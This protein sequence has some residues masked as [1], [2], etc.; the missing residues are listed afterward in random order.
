MVV[1]LIIATPD[2][3]SIFIGFFLIVFGMFFRAWSS[4]YINK[5]EELAC[6]GPY[7]LTRNPLYF[8]SF[9]IGM[10]IAVAANNET[11]IVIFGTYFLLFFP[12][13]IIIERRKMKNL[14]PEQ[15]A[16]LARRSNLFIP[17]LKKIENTDFNIAFYFKNKE[18]RVLYLSLFVVA[19]FIVKYLIQI[20]VN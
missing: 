5:N 3:R 2:A 1:I 18:Y 13:L 8:G 12:M 7:A 14:F 6:R 19:V 16:E 20:R 9:L 4:G 17:K 15:Y 10:G 11:A